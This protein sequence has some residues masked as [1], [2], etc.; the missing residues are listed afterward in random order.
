MFV[1]FEESLDD[2]LQHYCW[3]TSKT[4]WFQCQQRL[5]NTEQVMYDRRWALKW[6]ISRALEACRWLAKIP[7][8]LSWKCNHTLS[9]FLS[10]WSLDFWRKVTKDYERILFDTRFYLYYFSSTLAHVHY[11]NERLHAY[12]I[13]WYS[14]LLSFQIL[15]FTDSN[16]INEYYYTHVEM[17]TTWQNRTSQIGHPLTYI[18]PIIL[19]IRDCVVKT[20]G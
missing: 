19:T 1:D 12:D 14:N 7:C 15:S 18:G 10:F 16:F 6:L 11:T 4:W 20:T 3:N 9:L 2:A 8:Y 13:P 5:C 17:H